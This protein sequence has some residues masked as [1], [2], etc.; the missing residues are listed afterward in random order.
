MWHKADD[1]INLC[2]IT[3]SKIGLLYVTLS[4]V[5]IQLLYVTLSYLMIGLI[6]VILSN[7]MVRLFASFRHLKTCLF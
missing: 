2:N 4:Y 5:K 3:L 1:R 7:L 6:Y